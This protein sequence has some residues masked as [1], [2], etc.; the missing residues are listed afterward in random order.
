MEE[1][2]DAIDT[3]TKEPKFINGSSELEGLLARIF[4]SLRLFVDRNDPLTTKHAL[5]R[6][7][8]ELD[9]Y[10]RWRD[11]GAPITGV[12]VRIADVEEMNIIKRSARMLAATCSIMDLLPGSVLKVYKKADRYFGEVLLY[13]VEVSEIPPE[14]FTYRKI[15]PNKQSLL[16]QVQYGQEGQLNVSVDYALA[17]ELA[18]PTPFRWFKWVP[19]LG[20]ALLAIA[21]AVYMVGR[22][23]RREP[24]WA[25]V[26]LVGTLVIHLAFANQYWARQDERSTTQSRVESAAHLGQLPSGPEVI[27]PANTGQSLPSADVNHKAIFRRPDPDWNGKPVANSTSDQANIDTNEG[28]TCSVPEASKPM[29]S[30]PNRNVSSRPSIGLATKT[31]GSQPRTSPSTS[32]Q[33]QRIPIYVKAF[34]KDDKKLEVALL[35]TFVGALVKTNRFTIWTDQPGMQVP[36]GIYEVSIDFVP[37]KGC[38]G[39]ISARLYNLN[40]KEIWWDAKDCHEY[41]KEKMLMVTSEEMVSKIIPLVENAATKANGS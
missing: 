18:N 39:T 14:G 19:L 26:I 35:N 33:E 25:A 12:A 20:P 22:R 23:L 5:E 29:N 13:S 3:Q 1:K 40:S 34:A 41:P 28:E 10:K 37:V 21:G 31:N 9:I 16:L 17:N 11:S 6:A 7:R 2:H 38:Y 30:A 4:P 32:S 8:R 15:Y 27:G 24:S 36:T